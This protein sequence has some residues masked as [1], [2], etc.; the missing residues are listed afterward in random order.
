MTPAS[1]LS[2]MNDTTQSTHPRPGVLSLW[3]RFLNQLETYNQTF[4]KILLYIV[5]TKYRYLCQS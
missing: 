5:A 1:V 2:I 3:R 4:C